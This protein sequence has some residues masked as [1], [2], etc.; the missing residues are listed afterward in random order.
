MILTV[1]VI[2]AEVAVLPE[3][4]VTDVIGFP[5][6][7]VRAATAL[8]LLVSAIASPLAGAA[9]SIL[10]VSVTVL[11]LVVA[12]EKSD[13]D[14][15]AFCTGTVTAVEVP[16]PGAGLTIVT[17]AFAT[18]FSGGAGTIAVI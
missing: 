5:E 16:P 3:G 9:R 18:T 13:R 17:L 6:L 1:L 10:T 4:T 7:S 15:S 8:L 12:V 2:L 14:S 11:P